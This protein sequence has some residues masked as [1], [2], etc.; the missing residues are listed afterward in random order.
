MIR[1]IL[2]GAGAGG[3]ILAALLTLGG[4]S[5]SAADQDARFKE[6]YGVTYADWCAQ[7]YEAAAPGDCGKHR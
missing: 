7:N 3:A 4:G 1:S 5:S 2:I 6:M